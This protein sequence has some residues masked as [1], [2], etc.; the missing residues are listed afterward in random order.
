MKSLRKHIIIGIIFSIILGVLLHYLYDF[1]DQNHIL[2]YFSAINESAWEHVKLSVYPL[3]LT[4]LIIYLICRNDINNLLPSLAIAAVLPIAIIMLLFLLYVSF[5]KKAVLPIDLAIYAISIIIPLKIIEKVLLAP[6]VSPILSIL[7]LIVL[8]FTIVIL[9]RFTYNPPNLK[10][11]QD[12][13]YSF[14]P[15]IIQLASSINLIQSIS[16]L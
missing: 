12:D 1:L 9:F 10:I 5:T 7:S 11:F 16:E 2:G 3:L 4:T 14:L 8:I 13:A 15:N 6:Q